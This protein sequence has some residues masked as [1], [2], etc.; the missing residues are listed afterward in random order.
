M[1]TKKIIDL[2]ENLNEMYPTNST[3]SDK[4]CQSVRL[5]LAILGGNKVSVGDDCFLHFA[6]KVQSLDKDHVSFELIKGEEIESPEEEAKETPADE[7]KE[8]T[9]LGKA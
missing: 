2:S 4:H 7:K 8:E 1:G 6:A 3:E 5:P 9:V